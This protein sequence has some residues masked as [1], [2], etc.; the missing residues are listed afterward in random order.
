MS[1]Q[2]APQNL[3]VTISPTGELKVGTCNHC[4]ISEVGRPDR[5][6]NNDG[7]KELDFNRDLLISNL[8]NLG[9]TV[10]ISQEYVCP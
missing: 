5:A 2:T 1:N 9:V 10:Q 6:W 3:Y 7:D 8:R 4:V